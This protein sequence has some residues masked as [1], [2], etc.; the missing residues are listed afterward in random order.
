MNIT[1]LKAGIVVVCLPV[2]VSSC[3]TSG[4]AG[5]KYKALTT[6]S[7]PAGKDSIKYFIGVTAYAHAIPS[8]AKPANNEGAAKNIFSL[9]G[10]GQKQLIE[11]IA[12]NE[13]TSEDIYNKLAYEITPAEK[14]HRMF[15]GFGGK[16]TRRLVI[17]VDDKH[18]TQSDKV[19]KLT[20][21]LAPPQDGNIK[22]ESCGKVSGNYHKPV[23]N[24]EGGVQ[25][26]VAMSSIIAPDGSL[27]INVANMDGN[28]LTGNI[29]VDVTLR[30]TGQ[31]H[32][33]VMYS[34]DNLWARDHS[35]VKPNDIRPS[36][37]YQSRA[38][39]TPAGTFALSY[40]ATVKHLAA[41]ENTVSTADDRVE[42]INGKTSAGDVHIAGNGLM[43]PRSWKITDGS[44]SLNIYGPATA[45]V[46]SFDS[47]EEAQEFMLWFKRSSADILANNHISN[48]TYKITVSGESGVL[49]DSFIENCKVA[50]N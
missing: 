32:D 12:D 50:E 34:F 43:K 4:K 5:K 14:K 3:M 22:I 49:T 39:N 8:R 27:V 36:F 10:E 26:P 31:L 33:D 13:E 37:H 46:L 40:E 16:I 44:R 17:A 41:G 19:Q 25:D 20:I 9:S 6:R 15:T 24:A 38:A 47:F 42:I 1:F 21:T 35:A 48:G 11:S 23:K 29:T 2:L 45:G 30:Y 28:E 18:M 7:Y